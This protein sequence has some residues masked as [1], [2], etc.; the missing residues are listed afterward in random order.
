[1]NRSESLA[2]GTTTRKTN[3]GSMLSWQG[4]V[5]TLVFLLIIFFSFFAVTYITHGGSQHSLSGTDSSSTTSQIT[6]AEM[7]AVKPQL[8]SAD[9]I[10]KKVEPAVLE[11]ADAGKLCSSVELSINGTSGAGKV[12][13]SVH[14]DWAPLGAARFCELVASK[15]YDDVKFFRVLKVGTA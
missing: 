1:M 15:Y 13:I 5:I 3:G 2:M 7:V 14:H 4:A 10:L 8:R 12:L 11:N 6:P 9:E